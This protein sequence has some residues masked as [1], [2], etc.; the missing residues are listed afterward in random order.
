MDYAIYDA[1]KAG[2]QWIVVLSNAHLLPLIRAHMERRWGNIPFS[3]AAQAQPKRLRPWGTAHALLCCRP[4]VRGSFLAINADDFYGR[5]AYE[6]MGRALKKSPPGAAFFVG[7]ALQ[8]TLSRAGKVSRGVCTLAETN[9]LM[10]IEEHTQIQ[11]KAG[12]ITNEAAPSCKLRAETVVS[13]NFFGFH[14]GVFDLLETAWDHFYEVQKKQP[15][16]GVISTPR[17]HSRYKR[18]QNK[19]TDGRPRER[20]DGRDLSARKGGRK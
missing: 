20:L 14:P 7:Y 4:F 15:R 11:V 10:S 1:I 6:M 12:Q 9:R 13:M 2:F 16:C 18:K 19:S 8:E 5:S 17:T 3:V